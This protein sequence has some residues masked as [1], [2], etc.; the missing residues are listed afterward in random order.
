[1]SPTGKDIPEPDLVFIMVKKVNDPERPSKAKIENSIFT[2]YIRASKCKEELLALRR[3]NSS[4]S[5]NV[6]SVNFWGSC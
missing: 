5:C 2:F 1:M 6:S 3:S 4:L